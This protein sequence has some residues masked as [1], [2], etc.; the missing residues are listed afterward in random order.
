M[1][2]VGECNRKTYFKPKQKMLG[3]DINVK[4][5]K[6]NTSMSLLEFIKNVCSGRLLDKGVGKLYVNLQTFLKNGAQF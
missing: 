3:A 5:R 2:F 4:L 1:I 6:K